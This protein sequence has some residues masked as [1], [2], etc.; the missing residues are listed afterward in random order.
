[1]FIPPTNINFKSTFKT[2]NK[3]YFSLIKKSTLF[4]K[5]FMRIVDYVLI[6]F[7]KREIAD[8]FSYLTRQFNE[9]LLN[10]DSMC[11]DK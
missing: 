1:M 8:K 10:C 4:V 5:D 2:V 3:D 6:P 9:Q 11:F 7:Y